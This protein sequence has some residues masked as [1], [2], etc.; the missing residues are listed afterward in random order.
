[1]KAR[2]P[3]E[4][5]DNDSFE[6]PGIA[7]MGKP[8]RIQHQVMVNRVGAIQE[9][10]TTAAEGIASVYGIT[11]EAAETGIHRLG[12]QDS[13]M[14]RQ[15]EEAM[16]EH[17]LAKERLRRRQQ[18]LAEGA[19][20]AL[21]ALFQR[22]LDDALCQPDGAFYRPTVGERFGAW[23]FDDT[24]IELQ[25]RNLAPLTPGERLKEIFIGGVTDA[26]VAAHDRRQIGE[27]RDRQALYL[28][29]ADAQEK[30]AALASRNA[31]LELR[32]APVDPGMAAPRCEDLI[33]PDDDE[34]AAQ[35]DAV[36]DLLRQVRSPRL[37]PEPV[38][39]RRARANGR[40]EVVD[41]EPVE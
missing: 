24:S 38:L 9:I 32:V 17:E 36:E 40:L 2:I 20:G 11:A 26:K 31:D 37:E 7:R 3:V 28:Q 4:V 21:H 13:L 1:M 27:R 10:V 18:Q 25:R 34:L 8:A 30:L 23:F 39:D 5:L 35:I 22:D 15:G 14:A 6:V 19:S 12:R 16:R 33:D 41:A 29:L